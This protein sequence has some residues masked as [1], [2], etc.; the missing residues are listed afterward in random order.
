M[1]RYIEKFA[2]DLNIATVCWFNDNSKA[3][4]I[5]LIEQFEISNTNLLYR[6]IKMSLSRLDI[7]KWVKICEL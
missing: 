3:F 4:S 1:I 7:Q 5:C 2:I 6:H